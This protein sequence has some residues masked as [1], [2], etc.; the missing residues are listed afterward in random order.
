[1]LHD[2]EPGE[3]D[4]STECEHSTFVVVT[5]E[6]YRCEV[7]WHPIIVRDVFQAGCGFRF[8]EAKYAVT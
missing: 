7:G 3:A 5:A 4:L 6:H 1:M 8:L 2:W